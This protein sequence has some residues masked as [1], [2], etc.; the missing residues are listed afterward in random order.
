MSNNSNTFLDTDLQ[1]HRLDIDP[2]VRTAVNAI[3]END[4]PT[5]VSAFT[6]VELKGNFI[7]D[8]IL[9]R[10]KLSDSFE[11][12]V[13]RIRN[14]GG[15]RCFLMLA[16]FMNSIGGVEYQINPWE[17]ARRQILIY[18]DGQ[19]EACWEEFKG[20]IDS[21]F[22]DFQ[23]T[24]ATEPPT[25][26]SGSW[27]ATIPRCTTANAKCKVVEFMK[28]HTTDLE[29]LVKALSSIDPT[30]LTNELKCIKQIAEQT[31]KSSFPWEGSTCRSVG[32]LLIA[33]QSKIGKE[34]ISSNYKEHRQMHIPLGYRFREF[35]ISKIR[36]K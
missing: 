15:R 5:A 6:L 2:S 26:D 33:L 11:T 9:L 12:A 4:R 28:H 1:I 3:F 25:D 35:E 24:R 27:S 31:I 7:Q 34:L 21:V 13:A 30:F 10:R 29:Q 17:E 19:I 32:D 16:Q 18:L 20:C 8:I 23:C 14:S 22:D 36:S